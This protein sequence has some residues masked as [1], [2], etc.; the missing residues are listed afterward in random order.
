MSQIREANISNLWLTNETTPLSKAIFE[1][2]NNFT[3]VNSDS[4][5]DFF[6]TFVSFITK[7]KE[8]DIF[9][10]SLSKLISRSEVDYIIHSH[11]IPKQAAIDEPDVAI[12]NNIEGAHH[13]AK[14]AKD[15]NINVIH[16]NYFTGY[17]KEIY[18]FAS[19]CNNFV[20]TILHINK[21]NYVVINP[22]LLYSKYGFDPISNLLTTNESILYIDPEKKKPIMHVNDF[23]K[24]ITMIIKHFDKLKNNHYDIPTNQIYTFEEIINF[25]EDKNIEVQFTFNEKNDLDPDTFQILNQHVLFQSIKQE[26]DLS[27]WIN[28]MMGKV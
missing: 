1:N 19:M 5:I 24:Y 12:R 8:V 28:E 20:E 22:P 10:P 25:I 13:I 18:D 9:D 21:V 26:Y 6:K 15:Y 7:E 4:Y 16:V 23:L 3:I 2:F 27:D 11:I 17:S 14:I